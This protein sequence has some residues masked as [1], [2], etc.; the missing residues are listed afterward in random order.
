M[1]HGQHLS[2]LPDDQHDAFTAIERSDFGFQ[3]RLDHSPLLQLDALRDLAKF[4]QARKMLYFFESGRR[5]REGGWGTQPAN[6]TL[7][8]SFDDLATG[9]TLIILKS[10]HQQPDYNRLLRAFL[11]EVGDVLHVD[12]EKVYQRPICT[13]I[14]ASP[15]RV[16]PYHIDD[17]HNLLMQVRG[18]KS[19]YVFDGSDPEILTPAERGAFW[20]GDLNAAT[21]TDAKQSKAVLYELGPGLGVHVPMPYPHW[22]RNGDDISVAVS[23]N[24]QPMHDRLMDINA[25]NRLLRRRGLNPSDPGHNRLLDTSKVVAFRTLNALRH[26]A[27]R[28]TEA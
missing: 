10:V 1:S 19:F 26:L 5:N 16:T 12:M 3:H 21:L 2:L 6:V 28:G 9:A 14:L 13:V 11:T 27:Q 4:M 23:I 7:L 22:A 20:R 8:E 15:K 25:F 17:S 24:F 18:R